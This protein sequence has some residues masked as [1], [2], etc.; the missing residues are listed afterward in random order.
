VPQGCSANCV[1]SCGVAAASCCADAGPDASSPD[2]SPPDAGPPDAGPY[3]ADEVVDA[4]AVETG[5]GGASA[6][7]P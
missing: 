1:D 6:A 7:S 3:D 4:P 2:A 5:T